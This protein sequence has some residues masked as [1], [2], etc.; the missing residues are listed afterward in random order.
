MSDQARVTLCIASC[1]F[2]KLCMSPIVIVFVMLMIILS[3]TNAAGCSVV[4]PRFSFMSHDE[5]FFF[6]GLGN[7]LWNFSSL[8]SFL[9][10]CITIVSFSDEKKGAFRVLL[11]KPV[12]RRN[13]IGGKLFGILS[14]LFLMMAF[15][16]SIFVSLIMVVYGGP[17]S[18]SELFLRSGSFVLLLFLNCSFSVGLSTFFC[19]L[20]G[21]AEA[22]MASIAFIAL[23]YLARTP[24]VP[25]FLGDLEIINPVSLYLSAFSCGINQN[26]YS[27]SIPY[28]SWA[29]HALP[30]VVLMV[31][32][33]VVITLINCTIFN[34][35]E[36]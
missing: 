26:L 9:S 34:K 24:W 11:T 8:F 28:L 30:Y 27:T 33:V 20:L 15:T 31:A 18:L 1:E 2:S 21:K 5:A 3:L 29:S 36:L 17:G 16:V 12:Y 22:M 10:V 25:S 6:V 4:L 23:E 14:F 19:I 13:G 32:E 7:F 35:E